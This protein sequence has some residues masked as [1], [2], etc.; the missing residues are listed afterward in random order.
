MTL[1]LINL[2]NDSSEGSD[3]EIEN[4]GNLGDSE[5]T[6]SSEDFDRKI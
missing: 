1:I 6:N 3:E 5:A 2:A 4:V